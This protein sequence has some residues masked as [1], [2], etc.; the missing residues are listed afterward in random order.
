MFSSPMCV[1]VVREKSR[2]E[3]ADE[4]QAEPHWIEVMG[5]TQCVVMVFIVM[6]VGK[7]GYGR[8]GERLRGPGRILEC[9]KELLATIW[10]ELAA[11]FG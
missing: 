4:M 1:Q 9:T 10:I 6:A 3:S 5:N 7:A 8:V 11:W 2:L